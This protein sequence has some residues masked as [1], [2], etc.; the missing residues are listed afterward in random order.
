VTPKDTLS[1]WFVL[2]HY[3]HGNV[4]V[5]IRKSDGKQVETSRV[6]SV[7]GCLARTLNSVYRLGDPSPTYLEWLQAQGYAYDPERPIRSVG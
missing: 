2:P 1:C 5:G 4:L 3:D 7:D 6:V